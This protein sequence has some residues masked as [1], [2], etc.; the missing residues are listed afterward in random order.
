MGSSAP[1]HE[2]QISDIML[3]CSTLFFVFIRCSAPGIGDETKIMPGIGHPEFA[4]DEFDRY[5]DY[6][7]EFVSG[8][9]WSFVEPA[10]ARAV[11]QS[12]RSNFDLIMICYPIEPFACV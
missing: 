9:L 5:E 7:E 10:E 3:F 1:S 4:C 12:C 2:A 11:A 6:N 8:S